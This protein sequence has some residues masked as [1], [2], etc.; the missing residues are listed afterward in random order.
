MAIDVTKK[1]IM[2]LKSLCERFNSRQ[3]VNL[4][5]I[6]FIRESPLCPRSG[7]LN[8]LIQRPISRPG[9]QAARRGN[10]GPALYVAAIGSMVHSPG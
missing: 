1:M 7:P 8:F 4:K 9:A 6:G 2:V 10:Y 5:R 3:A